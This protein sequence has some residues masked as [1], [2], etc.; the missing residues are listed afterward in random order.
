MNIFSTKFILSSTLLSLSVSSFAAP[1]TLKT[2]LAQPEGFGVTST[3][4]EGEKEAILINAQFNRSEALRVAADLLDS[5]KT[6]KTIFV[7]YGDPDYYFGLETLQEI[8]P[9]VEIIATPETVEH[10]KQTQA[11]KFAFWTPKMG[12]NAPKSVIIPQVYNEKTLN[13]D[14]Q[15]IEIKGKDHLIYLWIPSTQ[16]VVGGIAVSSG[17]HLW[18]ADTPTVQDRLE[19]LDTLK[20]IQALQ[21]K[22]VIPAHSVVDAAQNIDAVNFSI[23][24][25]QQYEKANQKAKTSQDLI[26]QMQQHYPTLKAIDSLELGAKVVKGEMQ[27][28]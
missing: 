15:N 20:S 9:K 2:H 4:I 7:S 28:K 27:W 8:F 16:A 6:L 22:I 23:D 14:N 11:A 24:Y 21:P 1:L 18:M 13:L 10:I 3:I 12:E 5:G 26:T 25:L 17:I 19:V